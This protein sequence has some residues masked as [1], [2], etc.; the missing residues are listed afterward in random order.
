MVSTATDAKD[1]VGLDHAAGRARCGDRHLASLPRPP[2]PPA[3]ARVVRRAATTRPC[4][5]S[6]SPT[7]T[8]DAVVLSD[9]TPDGVARGQVI[10]RRSNEPTSV[11]PAPSNVQRVRPI[12]G[13]IGIVLAVVAVLVVSMWLVR[14]PDFVDHVSVTN[15][16]GYDLN[17]DVSDANRDGWL[18]ISVAT[19]GGATTGPRTS[20][21]KRTRGSSASRTQGRTR[22]RS[23]CRAPSSRRTVGSVAV[24]GRG[25]PESAGRGHPSRPVAAT[26]NRARRAAS[27]GSR[28]SRSCRWRRAAAS[29]R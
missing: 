26:D 2:R 16:S 1:R 18:P 23:R 19:G 5:P 17:V 24:P 4:E 21:T 3:P 25:R 8:G 14:G 22:A 11:E 9:A 15:R 13:K 20:S 27:P 7:R 28:P 29:P 6:R 12:A 10:S